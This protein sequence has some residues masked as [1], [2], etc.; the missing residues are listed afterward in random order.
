MADFFE[1]LNSELIAFI[2]KQVVFFTATAPE[3][4]R[5]SLSPKGMDSLRCLNPKQVAYLDLVGSG[6]ETAAHINQNGRMT[7][8]FCSFDKQPLILRLY[9]KGEVI[10]PSDSAWSGFS[11]HFPD[12]KGARQIILLN[13]E[14]LQTS[15]GY[16]VPRME[17]IAERPT[18]KKWCEGKTDEELQQYQISKNARSIDGLETG[19]ALSKTSIRKSTVNNRSKKAKKGEGDE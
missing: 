10:Q 11:K 3:Q 9:G 17:F 12:Y 1:A 7:I 13:I 18:L 6:N 19:L 4:G 15:C 8:M 14:S 5:I 16:G 2:E